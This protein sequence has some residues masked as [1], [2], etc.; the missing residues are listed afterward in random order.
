MRE[1]SDPGQD[2]G[3]APPFCHECRSGFNGPLSLDFVRNVQHQCTCGTHLDTLRIPPAQLALDHLA[4]DR[5]PKDRIQ[6][7]HINAGLATGAALIVNLEAAIG[8]TGDTPFQAC[9]HAGRS[10][11]LSAE[12]DPMRAAKRAECDLHTGSR[13]AGVPFMDHRAGGHTG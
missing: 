10:A 9:P 5:V 13:E 11:A 12:E 4:R 7:T 3:A 8:T 2:P 6:G 1:D